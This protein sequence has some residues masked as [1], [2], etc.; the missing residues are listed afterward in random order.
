MGK[1]TLVKM[2]NPAGKSGIFGHCHEKAKQL[3][4]GE[5]IH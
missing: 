4:F 2:N 5:I 3:V 1:K